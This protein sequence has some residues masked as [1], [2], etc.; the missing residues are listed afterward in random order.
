MLGE[1]VLYY[2][3]WKTKHH[4]IFFYTLHIHAQRV[5]SRATNLL[6]SV[7]RDLTLVELSMGCTLP[8][9]GFTVG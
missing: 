6:K 4:V 1:E 9:E 8:T 3:L 7:S 5:L 2:L